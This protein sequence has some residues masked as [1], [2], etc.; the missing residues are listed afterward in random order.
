MIRLLASIL[1]ILSYIFFW[2]NNPENLFKINVVKLTPPPPPWVLEILAV[3]QKEAEA[4]A[5]FFQT[6]FYAEN[7]IEVEHTRPD[8]LEVL[9]TLDVATRLDPYNMNCY[10]YAQAL[11]GDRQEALPALN[12][13]LK[14]GL[15]YRSWDYLI[16]WFL[17]SNYYFV[18]GDK[19]QAGKFFE[20]AAKRR[21]NSSL[22]ASLAARVYYEATETQKAI[23]LLRSMIQEINSPMLKKKL[24]KRLVAMERVN[25]IEN[26]INKYRS[27]NHSNPGSLRDLVTAGILSSIPPDP[28]GGKFYLTPR[29]TVDT[30]SH[31][32]E[33][34]G[35]KNESHSS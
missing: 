27:R 11:L 25:V 22:F 19:S 9:N 13:I 17:G 4:E 14:R 1:L 8:S 24:S 29:G 6:M 34:S 2:T 20:E 33:H 16:P 35:V 12:A 32:V 21:P 15:K 26:A 31:F 7:K 18:L 10:Y 30:T 5:L 23:L 28:Y 3:G